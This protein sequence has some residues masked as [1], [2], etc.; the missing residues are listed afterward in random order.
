MQLNPVSAWPL[1]KSIFAK[2]G[3]KAFYVSY[4]TTLT[5]S[6]PFQSVHFATYDFLSRHLNP[7]GVYNPMIH[8][9]AGGIAG[10]I[11]A[12]LTTPLDVSKTLL[13]TRGVSDHEIQHARGLRDAV[14]IIWKRSGWRGFFKG[15]A[16]RM[17]GNMP[18]TAISWG[19]Y[20]YFKWNLGSSDS[21]SSVQP[22]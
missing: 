7:Q 14:R 15:S 10:A 2:E 21:Q 9:S 5:L 20:E 3:L 8:I 22:I 12:L 4:P 1:A 13:Q 19:V 6:I 18:S 16:A 11:A 17:I